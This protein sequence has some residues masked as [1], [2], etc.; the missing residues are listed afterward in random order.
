ML[1][2]ALRCVVALFITS[3]ALVAAAQDRLPRSNTA[4]EL[5][6]NLQ[7]R[8]LANPRHFAVTVS[9]DAGG[10]DTTPIALPDEWAGAD[11]LYRGIR[12]L[13][14]SSAGAQLMP[15]DTVTR[16]IVR[17]K[18]SGRVTLTY[19]LID[20]GDQE[21]RR[22]RLYQPQLDASYALFFGNGA[23]VLPAW[24]EQQ[25]VNLSLKI[26][27][28]PAG[29]SAASSFGAALPASSVAWAARELHAGL[30]RHSVFAFGDFRLYRADIEGRPVWIGLRGKFSFSDRTFVDRT[31]Q[32]IRT[33][34]AFFNDFDVPHLLITLM[35]NGV[36]EGTSIGGTAVHRAFAMHVSADFTMPGRDF[37]FLVGHEHLHEWVPRRF[38]SME[39]PGA[40]DDALRYWFSEGITNW[41][42]HRLLLAS[43]QWTIEQYAQALS[44]VARKYETSGARHRANIDIPGLFFRDNDVNQLPYQRGE[45]LALHWDAQLAARGTSLAAVLRGLLLPP[46]PYT[47]RPALATERLLA[48]LE[49]HLGT[50]PRADVERWIERPAPIEYT[51]DLGGPCLTVKPVRI[52]RYELGFD[53]AASFK[54]N[55]VVGLAP[56]SAAER[57]GVREGE[58]LKGYSVHGG[59]TARDVLLQIERDGRV[60]DVTY[61]PISTQTTAAAVFAVRPGAASD[62][63]CRDWTV[64]K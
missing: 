23:W 4:Q 9:F 32:L 55:R 28:L 22:S 56:G 17:H 37:D 52:E 54:K 14:A 51:Q 62:H 25:P 53:A 8:W 41:L 27:G 3:L 34:R 31:A 33:H 50:G 30:L 13:R 35:P 21:F 38:G 44:D 36:T 40:K 42:T 18:R 16:R 26:D 10:R 46:P 15:G 24:H 43:G 1:V 57:A 39:M 19:E 2:P 49:V 11:R 20:I 29:W 60:E 58:V 12:N 63:A 6:I 48:A 61:K 64:L 59:D 45:L 7:A 5:Q 47:E